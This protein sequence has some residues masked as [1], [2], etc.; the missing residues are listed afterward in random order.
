M[1]K[2][3]NRFNQKGFSLTEIMVVVAIISIL[4]GI[5]I[6][7]YQKYQRKARQLEPKLIMGGIYTSNM[8]FNAEWGYSTSNFIQLGFSPNGDIQYKTGFNALNLPID[9]GDWVAGTALPS[10]LSDYDGPPVPS[11]PSN[12]DAMINTEEFCNA[13][14]D[15]TYLSTLSTGTFTIP[16]EAKIDN[17]EKFSPKFII[18]AVSN[19]GG[20]QEDQWEMGIGQVA[21]KPTGKYIMNIQDGL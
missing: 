4:T 2:I 10:A 8:A 18:I 20:A 6:P 17:T 16:T 7:Q 14:N 1:K 13:S 11:T 15:C 5:A 21:P 12:A 9:P 3:K 19:L